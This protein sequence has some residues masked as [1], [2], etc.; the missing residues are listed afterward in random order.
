MPPKYTEE[1]R[2]Q[3][4]TIKL[5]SAGRELNILAQESNKEPQGLRS[6]GASG[7]LGG[8]I[9]RP[10]KDKLCEGRVGRA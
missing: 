3:K 6:Q 4:T 7:E 5:L 9:G 1:C 8:S 10:S 2:D